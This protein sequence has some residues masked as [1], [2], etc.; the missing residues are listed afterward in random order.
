MLLKLEPLFCDTAEPH[1]HYSGYAWS[2]Y[3]FL[4]D[5][6]AW[7]NY[8]TN[9]I[10]KFYVFLLVVLFLGVSL[11]QAVILWILMCLLKLVF[12]RAVTCIGH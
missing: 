3:N 4:E 7:T 12:N 6:R 8:N 2:C 11:P 10:L 9:I 5:V 1:G